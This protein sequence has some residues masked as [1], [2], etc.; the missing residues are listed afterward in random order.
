MK[1]TLVLLCTAALAVIAVPAIAKTDKAEK[2]KSQPRWAHSYA[3]AIE[4]SRERG[5][6]LLA[7]F[8]IEH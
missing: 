5:C 2:T 4:E 6:Y 8:H 3:S 7:T 1:K